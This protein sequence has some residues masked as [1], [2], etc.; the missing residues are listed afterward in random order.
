[1]LPVAP[2]GAARLTEVMPSALAALS[3]AAN[4]LGFPAAASVVVVLVDGLGSAN[5]RARAGHA[6]TL[7]AAH[8]RRDV[9]L[10]TFPSTTAAALA[11]FT[12]GRMP[13]E[14][15]LV[16]YRVLDAAHDRMVNQLSG[17][18]A[19][20]RPESWQPVPT[21]FE[22]AR[23]AGVPVYAIGQGKYATSGFT[24]AVLRGA[25]YVAADAMEA[26]V[27]AALER[28]SASPSLC[29]LYIPELDQA[30]H[31]D[32]WESD[33]WLARLEEADRA[34]GELRR[35]MPRSTGL[36]VTADHG[37]VDVPE[38]RHVFLSGRPELRSGVRHVGGEP[39]CIALY[40]E[41]GL[42]PAER[43]RLLDGWREAE[44][45]RAWV[46]SRAEAIDAGLYGP[47]VTPAAEERIGDILIAVRSGVAY[48]ESPAVDPKAQAMIGQHGSLSDEER[49]VPLIR[50]GAFAR[51]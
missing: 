16:G 40:L 44:G 46:L 39:R 18:D 41:P 26:R 23:A 24:R 35:R 1:M 19:G 42:G 33:R 49:R 32:G 30:A 37:V 25:E 29:Y 15:G 28:V 50:L 9:A 8:G 10:T 27:D 17:W 14:H 38:H 43:E 13:G 3:G 4:P 34:I 51:G 12:T 45:S 11:S 48:Y 2:D 47:V 36:V 22:E 7:S 20:M 31:K 6:R 5:L 21:V